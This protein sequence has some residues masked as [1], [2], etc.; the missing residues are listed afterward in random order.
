[1]RLHHII[2]LAVWFFFDALPRSVL[3][4]TATGDDSTVERLGTCSR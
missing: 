3:K 2:V 4:V 1:M